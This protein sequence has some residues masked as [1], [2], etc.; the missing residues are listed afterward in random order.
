M[1]GSYWHVMGKPNLSPQDLSIVTGSIA[2][3]PDLDY[4]VRDTMKESSWHETT[5]TPIFEKAY[6]QIRVVD[7][8]GLH[9]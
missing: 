4:N 9:T 8:I 5:Y 3:W 2:A 7:Q 6:K 1:K